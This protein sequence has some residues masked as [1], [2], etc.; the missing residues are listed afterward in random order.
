MG[1]Q[2][3]DCYKISSK[4]KKAEK[5]GIS[6]NADREVKKDMLN[7]KE[8]V[9]TGFVVTVVWLCWIFLAVQGLVAR[10]APWHVGS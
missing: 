1:I 7:V 5:T 4:K 8:T 2:L 3:V 6:R 10:T 9:S